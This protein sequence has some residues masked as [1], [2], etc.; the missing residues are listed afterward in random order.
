MK[1]QNINCILW[2]G[3]KHAGKTTAATKLVKYLEQQNFIIGGILAPSKYKNRSLVGFDIID[4][5][6]N[7]RLP[8]AV[9]DIQADDAVP[10]KYSQRGIKLGHSALNFKANS[11]MDLVIVDEFGPLEMNG[12]GWREDTDRLLVAKESLI[13]IVVRRSIANQV[14]S[15]YEKYEPLLLE[16]IDPESVDRITTIICQQNY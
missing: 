8:L 13:L 2:V 1:F 10:Y 6:K 15:L 5:K 11:L 12:G 9:R 7:V 3:D 4:I 16:A 14:K